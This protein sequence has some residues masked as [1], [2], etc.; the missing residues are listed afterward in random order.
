M[1]ASTVIVPLY[2]YPQ[3]GA[4]QP[5]YEAIAAYPETYFLVIVNPG[6]GPGPDVLP[7]ANYEREIPKLRSHSNVSV[8]GYVHVQ[9]AKRD[10][11]KVLRDVEIYTLWPKI[12]APQAKKDAEPLAVDGIF[13]DETPTAADNH[14]VA[15]LG[16]LTSMVRQNWPESKS[17][18]TAPVGDTLT[19]SS[20]TASG[21][22]TGIER[23][24]VSYS[25]VTVLSSLQPHTLSFVPARLGTRPPSSNHALLPTA[26]HPESTTFLAS[27]SWPLGREVPFSV[28][29]SGFSALLLLSEASVADSQNLPHSYTERIN[30]GTTSQV[31]HRSAPL[32]GPR[33]RAIPTSAIIRP[34]RFTVRSQ[35]FTEC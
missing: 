16:S 1:A 25:F 28:T 35:C 17:P 4:W 2:I 22:Q 15:F 11:E 30:E 14:T 8:Y 21:I 27:V 24:R 19:H 18:H 33:A 13:V 10:L 32:P 9:W 20:R 12:H 7:D 5:L 34:E 29:S 6:N 26:L 31:N 23:P 3:P